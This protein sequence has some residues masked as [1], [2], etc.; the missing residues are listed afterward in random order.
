MEQ[1]KINYKNKEVIKFIEV[2]QILKEYLDIAR[3]VISEHFKNY[4]YELVA[5]LDYDYDGGSEN[6]T[7]F[8][9][10]VLSENEDE[11][12]TLDK[13]EMVMECLFNNKMINPL[14]FNINLDFK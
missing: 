6:K 12:G 5:D 14:I 7:L 3:K 13:L 9:N 8:L 1:D 2:N 11:N 4:N 10:I